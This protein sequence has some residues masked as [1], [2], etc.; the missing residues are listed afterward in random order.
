MNEA[1][2]IPNS[3]IVSGLKQTEADDEVA[4][5][6]A[7]YGSINRVFRIDNPRSQFHKQSIIEFT[8]GTAMLSLEP[9]LPYDYKSLSQADVTYHIRALASVYTPTASSSATSSYI[10]ELQAIAKL[11]GKPFEAVLQEQMSILGTSAAPLA[12]DSIKARVSESN[13]LSEQAQA[14]A[15]VPQPSVVLTTPLDQ[16]Y[17]QSSDPLL[18]QMNL[19]KDRSVPIE[20]LAEAKLL[21]HVTA[22]DM[23][24][25]EVQRVI[26]EHIVRSEDAAT[27]HHAP[28]RLRVFSGRSPRPIN[29]SDYDTWRA[30]V[31]LILQD[32]AISDRHRSRRI[33]D[34]LLPPAADITKHVS[35]QASPAAYL[36][37]LDSAYG[38]VEDGDELFALFMSTLQDSGEKSSSY[39]YRLQVVLNTAVR[40][41][42]VPADQVDRHL[43]KQF[44]RGCWDNKLLT[45]LQLEQRRNKPPSFAELLLLIRT[46]EDKQAAKVTR[47]KQHLGPSKQRIMSHMQ[48]AYVY[49]ASE[50]HTE[51]EQ[52][53][54]QVAELQSQLANLQTN[55]SKKTQANNSSVSFA[56]AE[57]PKAESKKPLKQLSFSQKTKYKP[58][59]WYCFQCGEDGHI[60]STCDG[61]PNPSLVATKKKLL[62]EKQIQWETLNSSSDTQ[63]LN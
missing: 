40:R 6:L 22:S 59:P 50:V 30:N 61:E 4:L 57:N 9:L 14:P 39:L 31:E 36:E 42:G 8:Y 29:E 13:I 45:D 25:P 5:Y 7:T 19:T 63:K 11:S 32:P 23:N 58:R 46:E 54:Q 3:V 20:P 17:S 2:K 56:K 60:A 18:K 44:C 21:S 51:T 55:R 16:K 26:V 53:K 38:T 27:H 37:L 10:K 12:Q 34:S 48:G 62:R 1:I 49:A 28:S 15:A 41:G 43:L 52:L 24:P 35:P 33:L 47:M